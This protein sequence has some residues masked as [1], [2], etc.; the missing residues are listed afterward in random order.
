MD[1]TG[2]LLSSLDAV[3]PPSCGEAALR[4]LGLSMAGWNVIAAAILAFA[5]LRT[6]LRRG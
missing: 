1:L 3:R 5:A 4:V 2:D 6:A